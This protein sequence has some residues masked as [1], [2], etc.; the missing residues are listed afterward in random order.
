MLQAIATNSDQEISAND[1]FAREIYGIFGIPVDALDR[2]EVVRKIESAAMAVLPFLISTANLNFLIL[3]QSDAEFRQ[4]LLLSDLCTADGM[5]IVWLTWLMG[6]PIK[7]RVAG[8]DVFEALKGISKYGSRL[9]VFFFG[10][11]KDIASTACET[12]NTQKCGM[13]CVGSYFPGFGSVDEMS[14]DSIIKIINSSNANFLMVSLGAIKGQLWLHRN[15]DRLKVPVRAHLGATINF[16]AG[17]LTRAPKFMQSIGLEWLWRIKEE[18]YLWRRYAADGICLLNLIV[19]RLIPLVA[20]TKWN[21]FK[22]R[23]KINDFKIERTDNLNAVTLSIKGNATAQ[24]V[25]TAAQS[26]RRAVTLGKDVVINCAN[27]RFLD[28]RFVGL[29]LMLNKQ[30]IQQRLQL[31]FTEV[32]RHIE[33]IFR[34]S[35]FEF[36]LRT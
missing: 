24:N 19:T 7:A 4:S 26:F 13:T 23:G 22:S 34:L 9:K 5:A 6:I 18:P 29:L 1:D 32:P 17:T 21:Q 30:L 31:R 20:A 28:A 3:S 14:T 16:Q 36:L 33:R 10:G 27:I 15:H 8:S 35:G 25:D 12:L 11:A 2:S